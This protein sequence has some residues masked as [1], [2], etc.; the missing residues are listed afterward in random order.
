MPPPVAVFAFVAG[1]VAGGAVVVLAGDALVVPVADGEV[2]V[3]LGLEVSE[4]V[5]SEVVVGGVVVAEALGAEPLLPQAAAS[6]A[7]EASAAIHSGAATRAERRPGELGL[8]ELGLAER[9]TARVRLERSET[10]VSRVVRT[11]RECQIWA[12]GGADVSG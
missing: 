6:T 10:M 9:R 4:V 7:V 3:G 11:G 12:P 5:V 1:G 2:P 8:A